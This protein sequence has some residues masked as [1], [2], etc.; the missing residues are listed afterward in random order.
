MNLANEGKVSGFLN[1]FASLYQQFNL[2]IYVFT[3]CFFG[4]FLLIMLVF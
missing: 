4:R 3:V 2:V 1:L